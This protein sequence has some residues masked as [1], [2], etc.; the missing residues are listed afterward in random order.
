M[1]NSELVSMLA[2]VWVAAGL[3]FTRDIATSRMRSANRLEEYRGACVDGL[4]VV[5]GISKSKAAQ[6]IT[7]D[8]IVGRQAG[9]RSLRRR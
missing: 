3:E 2:R 5:L 9:Y 6:M 8:V 7:E 1:S 4:A